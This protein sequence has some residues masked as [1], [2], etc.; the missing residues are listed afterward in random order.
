MILSNLLFRAR[1]YAGDNRARLI[2]ALVIAVGALIVA[3]LIYYAVEQWQRGRFESRVRALEALERDASARAKNLE[4][5]ADALKSARDALEADA[6]ELEARAI[7]AET[8]LRNAK[9]KVITLKEEY[10]TIRYRDVPDT[11]VSVEA[12]CAKLAGLGYRC[13]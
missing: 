3:A 4:A 7:T 8:A 2:R 11:P 12:A 5:E 10:E 9:G 13:E 1:Q 6:R